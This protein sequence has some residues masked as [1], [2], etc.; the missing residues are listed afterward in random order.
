MAKNS[1]RFP[2]HLPPLGQLPAENS[3]LRT[4]FRHYLGREICNSFSLVLGVPGR[5]AARS[6]S[7]QFA[8][9]G[10]DVTASAAH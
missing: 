8:N 4:K 1:T 10:G 9:L 6:S 7:C 2:L 3:D 5:P